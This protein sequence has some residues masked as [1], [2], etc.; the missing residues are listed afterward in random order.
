M[1]SLMKAGYLH[2]HWTWRFRMFS[3]R[4]GGV[5]IP[6]APEVPV[7]ADEAGLSSNLRYI[8]AA[9]VGRADLLNSISC[10]SV[11]WLHN[12]AGRAMAG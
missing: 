1:D 5:N 12:R 4:L 11:V 3:M 7:L 9:A 10:S 2:R 8:L 6:A